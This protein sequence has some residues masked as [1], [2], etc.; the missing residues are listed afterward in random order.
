[1]RSFG[2]LSCQSAH[3]FS[4][5]STARPTSSALELGTS[6]IASPVAGFRTSMVSPEDDSTHSP[7][8]NCLC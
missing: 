7:P 8:M 1:M 2:V 6:A 5:A 4:A 3:A